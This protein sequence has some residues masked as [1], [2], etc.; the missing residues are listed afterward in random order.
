M[1]LNNLKVF[2]SWSHKSPQNSLSLPS[3]TPSLSFLG[4]S[5]LYEAIENWD[6][7]KIEKLEEHRLLLRRLQPEFKTRIN[8]N[9]ILPEI[10]ECLI[11]QECEE[12]RQVI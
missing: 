8:P 9:D 6:F 4:Y 7:H 12:I 10:S 1:I 5:G 2:F 11:N 3:L